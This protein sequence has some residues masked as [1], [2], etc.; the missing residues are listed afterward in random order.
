[1]NFL[2]LLSMFDW[3]SPAIETVRET[4]YTLKTGEMS[5][6][7]MVKN[8]NDAKNTLEEK[9]LTVVS[10]AHGWNGEFV[11]VPDKQADLARLLLGL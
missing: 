8:A 9:G 7:I 2:E 11:S 10:I 4:S 1:M 6:P 5:T 3:I